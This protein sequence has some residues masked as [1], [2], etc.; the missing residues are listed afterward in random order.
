MTFIKT[1]FLMAEYNLEDKKE[2][3]FIDALSQGLF[4]GMEKV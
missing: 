3:R 4:Q 1:T 2:I